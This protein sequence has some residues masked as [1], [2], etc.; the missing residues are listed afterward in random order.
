MTHVRNLIQVRARQL[1]LDP[2]R[3][4]PHHAVVD[5][6]L[7][8]LKYNQIESPMHEPIVQECRGMV[9]TRAD[10]HDPRAPVQQ[11]LEPRR[12]TSGKIDWSTARVL[13][14]LDGSLMTLYHHGGE[15]CVASSWSPDG[16]RIVRR[17]VAARFAMRSG[18][19]GTRWVCE[20]P[21]RYRAVLLHVRV[22]RRRTPHR[23]PLREAAHRP[24]WRAQPRVGR[25][26]PIELAADFAGCSQLGDGPVVPIEN[27]TTRSNR[28]ITRPNRKPRASSSSTPRSTASRSR[29]RATSR[30]TT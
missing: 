28:P 11:V 22:L 12:G 10:R 3:A 27:A 1:A 16:G 2:H 30:C 15:W 24:A 13:E 14:K 20:P 26:M 4:I 8:S 6:D 29:A 23:V 25:E 9:V 5:G 7:V 18:R 21:R 19:R 17:G